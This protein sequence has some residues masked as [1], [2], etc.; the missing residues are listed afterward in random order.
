MKWGSFRSLGYVAGKDGE[1]N[2]R[3]F[4]KWE[5]EE[6]SGIFEKFLRNAIAFVMMFRL[7]KRVYLPM[8]PS[9]SG[10][11]CNCWTNSA[12]SQLFSQVVVVVVVVF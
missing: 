4:V 3:I 8:Q 12:S 11:G 9:A 5:E 1:R 2:A 7:V 6:E 10:R